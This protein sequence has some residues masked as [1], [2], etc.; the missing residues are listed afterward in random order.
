MIR[1]RPRPTIRPR[2][3]KVYNLPISNQTDYRLQNM[4][5]L[6]GEHKLLTK[7]ND[8]LKENYDQLFLDYNHVSLAY[9]DSLNSQRFLSK[10]L[11]LF[12]LQKYLHKKKYQV[13]NARL[14]TCRNNDI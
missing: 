13:V 10:E 7:F 8:S 6:I 1:R 12:Y 3:R 11:V 4:S 2:T 9:Q 14:N 5:Y